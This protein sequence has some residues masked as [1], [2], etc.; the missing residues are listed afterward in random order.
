MYRVLCCALLEVVLE[1]CMGMALGVAVCEGGF[2]R[3][4]ERYGCGL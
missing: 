4:A 3:G 2:C 1:P